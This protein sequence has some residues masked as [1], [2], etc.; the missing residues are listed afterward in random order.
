MRGCRDGARRSRRRRRHEGPR[1]RVERA[2]RD[3]EQI[4]RE[5]L[6]EAAE[7]DAREDEQFGEQRGDELP[8]EL[9]T[10]EGRQRWLRDARR[11]LDRATRRGGAADPALARQA[12]AG[13][14]APARRGTRCRAARERRIRGLPSAR[15]DEGRPPLRRSAQA[16]PAAGHAGRQDQP[17]R[18]R[19]AQRQDAARVGAGL[20]RPGRLHR[21]SDRDRRRGDVDSADFGQLEPMVT[22]TEVELAAAGVIDAPARG[23]RRRRLLAHEPDRTASPAAGS[24]C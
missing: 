8:P 14:A 1:Q 6:E 15:G 24:R 16:L 18:P 17:H 3:Y 22:A 20:Q 2:T 19:L 9:A 5:I 21:G 4:A 13:S 10:R 7:I 12:A 23:G 11:R